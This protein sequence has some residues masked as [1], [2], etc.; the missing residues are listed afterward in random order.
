MCKNQKFGQLENHLVS[1]Q[2]CKISQ[3]LRSDFINRSDKKRNKQFRH[4]HAYKMKN[5]NTLKRSETCTAERI[6]KTHK[7][8]KETEKI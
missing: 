3:L 2:S 1:F 8:E 5:I 6:H 7:I 4:F